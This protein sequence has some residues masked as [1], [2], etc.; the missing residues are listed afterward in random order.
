MPKA[1]NLITHTSQSMDPHSVQLRSQL[2]D[3]QT[4]VEQMKGILQYLVT[5]NFELNKDME[6]IYASLKNVAISMADPYDSVELP[7]PD[8]P[9]D[10]LIN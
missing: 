5:T 10:D 3:L 7:F 8:E 6:V 1:A 4:Q 2:I 9:D